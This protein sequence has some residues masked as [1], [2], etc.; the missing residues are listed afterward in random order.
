MNSLGMPIGE[1][2]AAG[3]GERNDDLFIQPYF[4]S[5]QQKGNNLC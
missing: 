3:W 5:T 2:V 1:S 4:I